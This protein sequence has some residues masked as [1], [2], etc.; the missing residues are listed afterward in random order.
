MRCNWH[1]SNKKCGKSATKKA[2]I[3]YNPM[4]SKCCIKR[5]PAIV[6]VCDSCIPQMQTHYRRHGVRAEIR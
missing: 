6:P 3:S 2:Y 5:E 1:G 4:H